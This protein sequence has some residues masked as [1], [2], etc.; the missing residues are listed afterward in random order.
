MNNPGMVKV[1]PI[2]AY[3]PPP[4]LAGRVSAPPDDV[5]SSEEARKLTDGDEVSFLRVRDSN[6]HRW[7]DKHRHIDSVFP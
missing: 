3:R 6:L 5:L 7:I 2:R 4:E 1:V